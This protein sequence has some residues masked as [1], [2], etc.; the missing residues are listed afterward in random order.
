[1][2]IGKIVPT[3]LIAAVLVYGNSLIEKNRPTREQMRKCISAVKKINAGEA[4]KVTTEEKEVINLW[5]ID[6]KRLSGKESPV[7]TGVFASVMEKTEALI[8]RIKF[9]RTPKEIGEG[10]YLFYLEFLTFFMHY[11]VYYAAAGFLLLIVSVLLTSLKLFSAASLLSRLG[12]LVSRLC[13]SGAAVILLISWVMIKKGFLINT[14]ISLYYG[15]AG[16]LIFSC[17][18]LKLYD[19]NFPVWNRVLKNLILPAASSFMMIGN[20]VFIR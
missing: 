2:N 20:R 19:P 14:G 7:F 12:F 15:P 9:N 13:L 17:I 1:M 16:V 5:K 6:Y 4:A 3:L 10:L 18:A 8:P 11:H